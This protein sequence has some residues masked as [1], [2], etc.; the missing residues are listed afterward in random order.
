MKGGSPA[1][2]CNYYD[3]N[4][5]NSNNVNAFLTCITRSAFVC[6]RPTIAPLIYSLYFPRESPPCRRSLRSAASPSERSFSTRA[7]RVHYRNGG[8]RDDVEMK[9]PR[10][11][12]GFDSGASGE[13]RRVF[14]LIRIC[15][16]RNGNAYPLL[17]GRAE[18]RSMQRARVLQRRRRR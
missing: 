17:G 5:N 8:M 7:T 18:C 4:N 9:R 14:I 3:N 11:K 1:A 15:R 13:G 10:K 12:G 6:A 2:R 16:G